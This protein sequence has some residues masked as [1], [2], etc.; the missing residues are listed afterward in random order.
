MYTIRIAIFA[1]AMQ[2]GGVQNGLQLEF[3]NVSLFLLPCARLRIERPV[4]DKAHA[5]EMLGKEYLLLFG[6]VDTVFIASQHGDM[7]YYFS[8]SSSSLKRAPHLG[9]VMVLFSFSE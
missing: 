1:Y 4:I 2:K 7:D 3:S 9:Q 5:S 6:G 8:D